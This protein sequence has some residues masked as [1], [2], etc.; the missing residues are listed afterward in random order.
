MTNVFEQPWLLL[1]VSGVVLLGVVVFQGLLPQKR[2]WLF[3]AL[4]VIIA[5]GG[6]A[7]DYFVRTDAEKIRGTIAGAVKAA[8]KED[9][10]ALGRFISDDYSDSYNASKQDLMRVCRLWLSEPIIEKNVHRVVLLEIDGDNAR[11]VF[12]VRV[13]FDPQGPVYEYRKIMLFKL[14]ADLK[15]EGSGWLLTRVEVLEIDLHPADWGYIHGV[16][17]MF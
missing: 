4:P 10:E 9:V 14:Q 5:A 15:R 16:D 8:E 3:W 1:T 12:T 7:L 17:E 6:F 2:K 11:V 13:V